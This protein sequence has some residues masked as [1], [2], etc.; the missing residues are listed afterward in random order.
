MLATPS[1]HRL[2]FAEQRKLLYNRLLIRQC[3]FRP[4]DVLWLSDGSEYWP[5]ALSVLSRSNQT[6]IKANRICI[7]PNVN[8]GS[9][10]WMRIHDTMCERIASTV[11]VLMVT[12]R[13]TQM[14]L[15][16]FHVNDVTYRWFIGAKKNESFDWILRELHTVSG[17]VIS[18]YTALCVCVRVFVC[19]CLCACV[20]VC[21]CGVDCAG[22]LVCHSHEQEIRVANYLIYIII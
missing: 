20:Y 19:V 21:L 15:H 18:F 6:H 17:F 11:L 22:I 14:E 4:L 7:F 8:A 5:V 10:M 13:I 2:P 1:K 12:P 9:K 16:E 3:R